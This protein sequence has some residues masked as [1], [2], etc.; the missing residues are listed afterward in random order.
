MDSK[1]A[2]G[3]DLDRLSYTIIGTA[4]RVHSRIGPGCRES[5]YKHVMRGSLIDQSLH[6]S[7]KVRF[8]LNLREEFIERSCARI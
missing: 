7:P 2:K 5:I 4:L 3:C 1:D 8:L 6:V